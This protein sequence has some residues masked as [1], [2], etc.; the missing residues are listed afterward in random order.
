MPEGRSQAGIKGRKLARRAATKKSGPRGPLHFSWRNNSNDTVN[1]WDRDCSPQG[2]LA[3][4]SIDKTL[5]MMGLDYL[6]IVTVLLTSGVDSVD[7][8][9]LQYIGFVWWWGWINC[10]VLAVNYEAAGG[11]GKEEQSARN[12]ISPSSAFDLP[13]APIAPLVSLPE[14]A[15][16]VYSPATAPTEYL[17]ETTFNPV[18]FTDPLVSL[19]SESGNLTTFHPFLHLIHLSSS[20]A[21][22]T[23]PQ[24]YPSQCEVHI[25]ICSTNCEQ[26]STE[27]SSCYWIFWGGG[28]W[29]QSWNR[30]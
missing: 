8:E 20:S 27:S 6:S 29:W 5:V 18:G 10:L 26:F 7:D 23:S 4:I 11:N 22:P 13:P 21:T 12:Y 1:V 25:P 2:S 9:P 28:E 15:Q 16:A 24:R 14:W 3:L 17:P 30:I 19:A